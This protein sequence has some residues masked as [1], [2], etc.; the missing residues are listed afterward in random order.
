VLAAITTVEGILVDG[1]AQ[2]GP[3][4]LAPSLAV[5]YAT[6]AFTVAARRTCPC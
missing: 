2:D 4:G 6:V 1:S 3:P 5:A